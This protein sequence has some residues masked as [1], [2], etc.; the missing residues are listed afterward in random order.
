MGDLILTCTDDQSRNRQMGLKLAQGLSVEQ[1]REQIGQ[2]VEGVKTA[3]EAWKL[4]QKY[5]LDCPI[6]EQAYRVL[7]ENRSPREALQI[8][9]S[10]ESKAE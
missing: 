9:L 3:K 1:A 4:V 5:D 7:Y 10:R 6:I 2:A 8:L